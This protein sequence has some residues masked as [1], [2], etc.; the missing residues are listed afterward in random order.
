MAYGDF[1]DLP[2]RKTSDKVFHHKTFNIAQNPKYD[3][4]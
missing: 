4:Y 3:E 1:K 2:K